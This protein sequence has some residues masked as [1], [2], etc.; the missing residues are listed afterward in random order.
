[1]LFLAHQLYMQDKYD[2]LLSNQ[3]SII[4]SGLIR[5]PEF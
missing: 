3:M 4:S 1:L 5:D 2:I